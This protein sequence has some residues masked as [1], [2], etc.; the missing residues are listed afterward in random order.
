MLNSASYIQLIN[1]TVVRMTEQVQDERLFSTFE[2]LGELRKLQETLISTDLQNKSTSEEQDKES[3][4]LQKFT[5]MVCLTVIASL[6]ERHA[7]TSSTNIKNNRICLI[8]S[9]R[10]SLRPWS[11]SSR[12]TRRVSS[13]TLLTRGTFGVSTASHMCYTTML[14]FEAI[15]RSV[16]FPQDIS[17]KTP[18]EQD[19][20]QVLS[21]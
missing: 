20:S 11:K 1:P 13:T 10:T 14:N 16:S 21:S 19:F 7:P 6:P 12:N 18:F 2:G 17:L 8:H 3:L 15:K 4:T 5:V 9:S